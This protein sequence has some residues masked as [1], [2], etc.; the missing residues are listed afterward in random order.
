MHLKGLL[1]VDLGEGPDPVGR[2]ELL[3]IQHVLQNTQQSL[4]RGDGE[5]MEELSLVNR[6]NVGNLEEKYFGTTF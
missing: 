6:I 4:L 1:S 3:L 2:E 5:K